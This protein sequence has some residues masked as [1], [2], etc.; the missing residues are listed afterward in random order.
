MT[1]PMVFTMARQGSSMNGPNL[2]LVVMNAKRS[3]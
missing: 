3:R 1:K 2:R